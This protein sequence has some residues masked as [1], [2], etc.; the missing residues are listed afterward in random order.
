MIIVL[1]TEDHLNPFVTGYIVLC[2]GRLEDAKDITMHA[3]WGYNY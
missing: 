3:V 1:F 2:S